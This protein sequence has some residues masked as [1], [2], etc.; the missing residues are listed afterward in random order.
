MEIRDAVFLITGAS[1]GIGAATARAAH[2]HGAQV[3][4]V[5]NVS[6][7]VTRATIPGLGAYAATKL[8]LNMLSETARVEFEQD[9]IVVS[10]LLPATT[11]TTFYAALRQ[12]TRP[13]AM[14]R[15]RRSRRERSRRGARVGANRR[16]RDRLHPAAPLTY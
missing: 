5:V 16:A 3:G 6:S 9:G 13:A 4:A 15:S 10:N 12:G 8:A 2:Q 7:M 11:D 1:S 14:I